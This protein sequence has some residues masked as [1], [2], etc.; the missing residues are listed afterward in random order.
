MPDRQLRGTLLGGGLLIIGVLEVV[1]RLLVSDLLSAGGEL[2]G[3][4]SYTLWPPVIAAVGFGLVLATGWGPVERIDVKTGAVMVPILVLV[5]IGGH[6]IALLGGLGLYL[7]IDTPVRFALY[8]LEI[9]SP[10]VGEDAMFIPFFGWFVCTILVWTV[11]AIVLTRVVDGSGVAAGVVDALAYPRY[12]PRQLFRLLALAAGIV[13]VPALLMFAGLRTAVMPRSTLELL[14][15]LGI[16]ATALVIPFIWLVIAYSVTANP[17]LTA[18]S[19]ASTYSHANDASDRSHVSPRK[20][21][22]TPPN[23]PAVSLAQIAMAGLLICSLVATA[24]AIRATEFRPVDTDPDPLPDEPDELVATAIANTDR[25]DSDQKQLNATDDT[26]YL[27]VQ[28]DRTNRQLKGWG[29]EN[30]TVTYLSTDTF[31]IGTP[32]ETDQDRLMDRAIPGYYIEDFESDESSVTFDE[33][34]KWEIVEEGEDTVRLEPTGPAAVYQAGYGGDLESDYDDPEIHEADGWLVVD[35]DRKVLSH[36]EFH[37]NVSERGAGEERD[38]FNAQVRHEFETDI[39]VERP[40]QSES[41]SPLRV[42]WR[43]F[44]Y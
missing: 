33:T 39:D 27:R 43:L 36:A 29:P 12:R 18:L 25:A 20:P 16:F 15:E 11:P 13:A 40:D 6:A 4:A 37:I 21:D 14:G 19:E 30:T 38:E 24:G 23:R 32:T 44:L 42:F 7:L 28:L 26:L 1:S 31:Y 3:A 8:S 35:T 22:D 17:P 10:F 34:D 9:S 2:V 5:A 41:L